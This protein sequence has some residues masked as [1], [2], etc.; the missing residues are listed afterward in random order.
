MTASPR[1]RT[2]RDLARASYL[3]CRAAK[4]NGHDLAREGAEG[5]GILRSDRTQEFNAAEYAEGLND[6]LA[7]IRAGFVFSPF[8]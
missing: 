1:Q 8:L 6:R 3:S 5:H 2:E 7:A 4:R